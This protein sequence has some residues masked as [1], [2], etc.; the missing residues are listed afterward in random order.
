MKQLLIRNFKL[1][2]WTLL[3]YVLLLLFFPIFNLLN[4]YELPHSIISGSIGLILTIICLVDAGHLFR[5][6]RR[7]GGTNSYYF[8]GSL[9]V[10]KKDLL[11]ANYITCVVLTLLGALIISLYGY[12]TNQIKTDSIYFSTTYSFIVAN[13]FSIPIA[14]NKSTE[15]KNKDVP[16]IAYVFVVI[17][18][19]PFT[20]SV[21][22]T[23]INYLTRNDSHI[24]TVYSYFLNYGLLIIS[25][26]SLVINYLIQIKK[27]KN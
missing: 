13:F 1:R 8:F 16:Y 27:I 4:K 18:V 15:Q 12:E 17:V 20:L 3:I 26:I 22:F 5:V 21:I 19:L 24:P 14:F 7:L 2:R 11:N 6:N 9:P 25:I 10:S 23:L